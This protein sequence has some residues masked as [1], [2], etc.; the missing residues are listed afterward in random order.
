M[1]MLLRDRLHSETESGVD[2]PVED[3]WKALFS[4]DPFTVWFGC[5]AAGISGSEQFAQ[6]LF[7]HSASEI[8]HP[9]IPSIAVW[10]LAR[11]GGDSVDMGWR[12][13][14]DSENWRERRAV[15]DLLGFI[16]THDAIEALASLLLDAE[17]QVSDWAAL[18][19]SKYREAGFAVLEEVFKRVPDL[20]L[21]AVVAD[22]LFKASPAQ[23]AERLPSLLAVLPQEESL[24]V[25]KLVRGAGHRF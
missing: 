4:D 11:I 7:H 17:R 3:I 6:T 16:A 12:K 19:L 2:T 14:L 18:S 25:D 5:K 15:A 10:S 8:E 24:F 20:R 23:A 13:L 21:R 1:N 22:A 9:D